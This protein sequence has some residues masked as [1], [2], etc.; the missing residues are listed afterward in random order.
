MTGED[1]HV[2]GP[3]IGAGV[4]GR[5]VEAPVLNLKR[6]VEG[7]AGV[8]NARVVSSGL[9]LRG[10]AYRLSGRPSDRDGVPNS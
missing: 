8:T 2:G 3:K 4:R 1:R 7:N 10:V 5:V 9:L 6:H